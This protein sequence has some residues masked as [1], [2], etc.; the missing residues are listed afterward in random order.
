MVCIALY[1]WVHASFTISQAPKESRI[2]ETFNENNGNAACQQRPHCVPPPWAT[3]IP[4]T[5]RNWAMTPFFLQ[6][7]DCVLLSGSTAACL[8]PS[9]AP[10]KQ[11]AFKTTRHTN[12]RSTVPA[13]RR[14]LP[15]D[16]LCTTNGTGMTVACSLKSES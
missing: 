7:A 6:G 9:P 5:L 1:Q 8:R 14:V 10:P 13:V 3:K 4:E 15:A 12:S 11:S 2:L 16:H